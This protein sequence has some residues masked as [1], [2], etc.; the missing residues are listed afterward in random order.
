[1]K[2]LMMISIA[3]LFIK[4]N[5]RCRVFGREIRAGF[6]INRRTPTV[7]LGLTRLG[8]GI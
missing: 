3:Q 7:I 8:I 5:G 4:E 2:V 1:M 6:A